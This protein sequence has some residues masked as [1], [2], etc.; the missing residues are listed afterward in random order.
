MDNETKQLVGRITEATKKSKCSACGLEAYGK[1]CIYGPRG[2][3]L[4]LDDPTRCGWCGS[5]T[6]V[7]RGCIY[8]PTGYHSIG[9]NLYTNMPMEAFMTAYFLKRLKTPF[10][11]TPA[12]NRGIVNEAGIM[13]KKPVTEDEKNAYSI[14]DSFIFKL[15]RFLGNKLDLVNESTYLE[16]SKNAINEN[17][18]VEQFE[19]ELQLK[20]KLDNISREFY[21]TISDARK[22]NISEA[23]IDKAVLEAYAK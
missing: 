3:H 22:N 21:E 4:H 16:L 5:K 11:D 10:T 18:S 13:V 2:I 15:K 9:A 12:F 8:S 20:R 1:G 19:K 7:G 17:C 14:F 23:V 6:L